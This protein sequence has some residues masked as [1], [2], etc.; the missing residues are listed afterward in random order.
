MKFQILP[1]VA[2]LL[3]TIAPHR[4]GGQGTRP[5]ALL[6]E[7][8]PLDLPGEVDSNS[9]VVWSMLRGQRLVHIT[10]S[11]AGQPSVASGARITRVVGASPVEFS[12]HPGHGV[13]MEAIVADQQDTWY[14]YY[15]NEIPADICDRPDLVV[16]RIGAAR[17]TDHGITWEDLG[18]ILEAP[19]G[20]ESC[21]TTNTYFAGGVGDFSAVLDSS[22]TNLYIFFSQ[23]SA[24]SFA[25]GT[26]AARLPWSA[27]DRPV[28]RIDVWVDGAWLPASSSL[29]ETE[30]D[31]RLVWRYPS[32]TPLV[33]PERPWHDGDPVTDAFWGPSVHWNTAL[34]RYVM[35][36]NRTE[37]D[38]FAQEGIYVSFA[39]SL[40]DP[41]LWSVPE[42]LLAGGRWYPQVIGLE[43]GEGTDK[44]AGGVA[45]F[46]V[47]GRSTHLIRFGTR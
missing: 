38:T 22:A 7:A 26:A 15:H 2:L 3:V 13:W 5:F 11:T 20:G 35:L 6:V 14:G 46:F 23:Y 41:T 28:G 40:D 17:S 47:G 29:G 39:P 32:G 9:P 27:R 33:V 30:G 43:L 31:P 45:R 8:P 21:G 24:S 18:I 34:Q 12:S 42:R 44:L 16:P 19:A 1:L 25:Q 36:L 4:A 37:D 10:T